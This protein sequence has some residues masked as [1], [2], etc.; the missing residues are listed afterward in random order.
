M[1]SS[2]LAG[3]QARRGHRQAD[4]VVPGP[5]NGLYLLL[6]NRQDTAAAGVTV[7][8]DPDALRLW[9]DAMHVRWE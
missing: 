6:W 4:A 2:G 7:S 5:A 9:R 8:G 1:S 3:I